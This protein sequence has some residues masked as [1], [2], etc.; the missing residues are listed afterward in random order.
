MS[1]GCIRGDWHI[2]SCLYNERIEHEERYKRCTGG[3]GVAAACRV[4]GQ[5]SSSLS[6][7]G[8]VVQG[9]D[10]FCFARAASRGGPGLTVGGESTAPA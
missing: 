7:P 5:V 1:S 6:P 3:G 10:C 4:D 8:V 2:V 9:Q